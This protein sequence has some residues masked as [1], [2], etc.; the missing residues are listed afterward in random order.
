M[1][2][3]GPENNGILILICPHKEGTFDHLQPTTD[4]AHLLSD[5]EK[6]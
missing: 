2:G 3:N 6:N 4:L 5:F 1:N